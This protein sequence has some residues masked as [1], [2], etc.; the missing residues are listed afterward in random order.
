[1]RVLVCG[2]R[3]YGHGP[4]DAAEMYF[5]LRDI[6]EATPI[7][8]IIEGGAKGADEMARNMAEEFGAKAVTVP[9]LWDLHGKAAGPIRNQRMVDD[10]KPDLVVAFPGGRG[11]ADMVSRAKAAGIPVKEPLSLPTGVNPK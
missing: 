4:D 10:F 9:A 5:A 7:T 2:G 1:M 8:A 11:T 3:N 6:H